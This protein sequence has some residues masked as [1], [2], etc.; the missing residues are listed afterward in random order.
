MLTRCRNQFEGDA[1]VQA[2][3]MQFALRHLET[4]AHFQVLQNHHQERQ[5]LDLM[6]KG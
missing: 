3:E 1:T 5:A 6:M 2:S 4:Q